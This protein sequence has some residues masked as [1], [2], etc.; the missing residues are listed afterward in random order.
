MTTTK[1]PISRETI[2]QVRELGK[3]RPIVL[4]IETNG[5]VGFRAKGTRTTYW[6]SVESLYD[7]AVKRAVEDAR[8][9]KRKPRR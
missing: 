3:T 1:K 8:R 2:A 7:L 4:T 5:T 6:L 9:E